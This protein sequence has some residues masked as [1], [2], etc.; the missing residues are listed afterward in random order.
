MASVLTPID[1]NEI[2]LVRNTLLFG[3]L[4]P[5]LLKG[6]LSHATVRATNRGEMLFMQGDQVVACFVVLEGWVKLY[7]LTP[8][9][10]EAV[11][12]VFT[13][14]QSF[15][16]G[17]AF[18]QGRYPVSAEA[19][20]DGRLL[21]IPSHDLL[22]HIRHNPEIGLAM[23][24]ST[25]MH[26]HAL[27]RQIEQ[28]KAHTGVERVAGFLLSLCPAEQ[29]SCSLELPY[30]KTLIAGRLGMKPESLSRAFARLRELGVKIEHNIATIAD[31]DRLRRYAS[32]HGGGSEPF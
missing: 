7:R 12:A 3:G 16:E 11:V 19:V 15:A 28:L 14:G 23:L 8:G 10:E 32:A 9:G 1:Q 13:R 24:A 21:S 6:M 26:L 18:V 27:V 17:A 5:E 22:A 31:V 20:T 4:S 2:T 29:G 25:S 30:D